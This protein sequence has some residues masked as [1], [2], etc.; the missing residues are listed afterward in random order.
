MITL[1]VLLCMAALLLLP[2]KQSVSGMSVPPEAEIS[3]I[4]EEEGVKEALSSDQA[5]TETEEIKT[6]TDISETEENAPAFWEEQEVKWLENDW[7]LLLVDQEHPIAEDYS[8]TFKSVRGKQVDERIADDL[9]AMIKDA[10]E[11]GMNLMIV[12]AYRSYDRQSSLFSRKCR[13]YRREGLDE[14]E[15]YEKASHT[16]AAPGCSEHQ[17]GLAVDIVSSSHTALTET[18][19]LTEEGEWL[20]QNCA[21]YGFILRYPKGKEDVTGIIFE[22][23][24]FR[25]VGRDYAEQIMQQE[26]TLEEYLAQKGVY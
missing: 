1:E 22:P 17:L 26:I 15:A 9:S 16:V 25:Y 21:R 14:E 6:E 24:H 5:L 12:S 8:P 4:R 11:D 2:F 7:R 20:E 18:F 10:K 13:K 19:A 3:D 23:W